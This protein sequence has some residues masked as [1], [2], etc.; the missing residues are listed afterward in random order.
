M[1]EHVRNSSTYSQAMFAFLVSD[2][3]SPEAPRALANAIQF[4][5]TP[6]ERSLALKAKM[7][8]SGLARR[9]NA[10]LSTH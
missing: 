9:V 1:N 2:P 4:A 10:V 8:F 6:Q 3:Q 7:G 5:K